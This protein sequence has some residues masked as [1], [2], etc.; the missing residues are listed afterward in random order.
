MGHVGKR[1]ERALDGRLGADERLLVTSKGAH[2]RVTRSAGFLFTL[3]GG[4]AA[5]TI[6][7]ITTGWWSEVALQTVGAASAMSAWWLY[8]TFVATAHQ[9]AGIWPLVALTS[10]RLVF[11]ETGPLGRAKRATHEMS[12]PSITAVTVKEPKL[13]SWP[14]AVFR[15]SDGRRIEYDLKDA[16]NFKNE[17][18]RLADAG[19]GRAN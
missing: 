19:V 7:H 15:S 10:D 5:G 4:V 11:L 3:L 13:F 17:I 2:P 1:V 12:V 18:A 16:D 6:L 9:P 14:Q 8:L